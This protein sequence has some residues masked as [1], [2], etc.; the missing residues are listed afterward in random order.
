MGFD[1]RIPK[2]YLRSEL[3]NDLRLLTADLEYLIDW[4]RRGRDLRWHKPNRSIKLD[5][6][7]VTVAFSIFNHPPDYFLLLKQEMRERNPDVPELIAYQF[8]ELGRN[9]AFIFLLDE[10]RKSEQAEA[11]APVE[12]RPSITTIA[13]DPELARL[14]IGLKQ[15]PQFR[16]WMVLLQMVRDTNRLRIS[17]ADLV[18][19]LPKYGIKVSER[20][21]RRWLRQGHGL[22]WNVT[23]EFI[24]FI[25]YEKVAHALVKMALEKNLPDLIETN[26]P[27]KRGMYIDVSGS[28]QRFEAHIYAAWL[29][30][31]EVPAIA[32]STLSALFNREA[33]ILRQ[34]DKLANI[35]VIT[36]EVQ[37]TSN[38][39]A[40]VPEHAYM[41]QAKIGNGKTETRFR[42]RM[43]NTYRPPSI[44]EHLERGQSRRVFR[45][46]REYLESI[47]PAGGCE[48]GGGSD[49]PIGGLKPTGRRYFASLRRAK[50][51]AKHKGDCERYV[52]L[53]QDK[54]GRHIWDY[55]PDGRQRTRT[56]EAVP[57]RKQ[58]KFTPK[59]VYAREVIYG[60]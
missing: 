32:R 30:Y 56:G 43:S 3:E 19:A 20:N 27:G 55:S 34:W 33:R 45:T 25:S 13:V 57:L 54:Y 22:F 2:S 24:Y 59:A 38:H 52:F 6:H 26:Q 41:Y 14:A 36:N 53:G 31:R 10:A 16:L 4:Y 46:I 21:L 23:D 49:A 7:F 44:Q 58:R 60:K 1:L 48:R 51:H 37:F 5:Q 8:E 12:E 17:R 9:A 11:A 18:A 15:A 42:A 40:D 28:L 39:F 29:A 50:S 47:E 35:K